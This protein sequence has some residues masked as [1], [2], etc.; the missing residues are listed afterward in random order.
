VIDRRKF[1]LPLAACALAEPA[2]AATKPYRAP[3]TRLGQPDLEGYWTN[4]SYT[5]LE[6]PKEFKT[7]A[8]GPEEARAWEAKLAKTGGVNVPSD[9]LGQATSEFPEAG[10]GM[11]RIRGE[12]RSSF[13]VD[14]PDGQMPYTEDAKKRAG[15]GKHRRERYDSPEERP[16]PERCLASEAAGA[17]IS[18]APDT[19]VLQVVQTRDAVVLIAEKYHDAR[20]VRLGP[21][22]ATPGP[23]SWMGDSWGRWEGETLVVRT[24][25][26]RPGLI[27]RGTGLVFSGDTVVEERFTRTGPAEILYEFTV[28]DPSLFT[29][30]WRAEM[31]FGASPGRWFE[32]ACHEGNYSLVSILA[33][34]RQGRQEPPEAEPK[35]TRQSAHP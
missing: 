18:N 17:P 11:A 9:P 10:S 26:V 34:A 8:I 24:G 12:I 3:R 33:A 29:R 16:H 2:V 13:I 28:T 21:E 25:N 30:S 14:P 32:Y 15:L 19:N 7:L 31:V 20:I 5:E 23:K 4:A 35:P 22:P 1:V 6:R 27:E